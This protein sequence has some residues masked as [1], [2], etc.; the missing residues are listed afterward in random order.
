MRAREADAVEPGHLVDGF[1]KAREVAAGIV[2]SLVVIDDLSQE[3]H[4]AAAARHGL[5]DLRQNVGF[6]AHALVPA[7]VRHHAEAA[8][9]VA[10]LDDGHIGL[11]GIAA[12]RDAQRKRHVLVRIEVDQGGGESS[13][14]RRRPILFSAACSTSIGSRRIACVPTMT[15]ATPPDRL[16]MAAPS[17]CATHPATA[18]IG[19]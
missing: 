19:P 17:C 9:L 12:P 18:T 11:H 14:G 16:R 4:L 15:S 2:G 1:E 8:E 5:A 7:R 10:A 13:P 6:R 3:L